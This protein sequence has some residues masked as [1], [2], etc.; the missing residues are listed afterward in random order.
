[1]D[2]SEKRRASREARAAARRNEQAKAVS[3]WERVAAM[4][5]DHEN[6]M[7]INMETSMDKSA[8]RRASREARAAARRSEAIERDVASSVPD[9]TKRPASFDDDDSADPDVRPGAFREGGRTDS[10]AYD[11][12]VELEESQDEEENVIL[13][14]ELETIPVAVTL[15]K[16]ILLAVPIERNQKYIRF[17]LCLLL[18]LLLVLLG[19]VVGITVFVAKSPET[20][21]PSVLLTNVLKQVMPDSTR[22]LRI[23]K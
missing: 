22:N 7:N 14:A 3:Q 15:E 10:V 12:L 8:K 11:D 16:T 4:L 13:E 18:A 23:R 19:V 9:A 17:R 1:M 21:N 20:S 5:N 6:Q 2:E